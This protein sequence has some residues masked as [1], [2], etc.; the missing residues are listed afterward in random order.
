MIFSDLLGGC[1]AGGAGCE[2]ML[3]EGSENSNKKKALGEI[4]FT[5]TGS[6]SCFPARD[7]YAVQARHVACS[8]KGTGKVEMRAEFGSLPGILFLPIIIAIQ[9]ARSCFMHAGSFRKTR[10]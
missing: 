9:E 7:A 10:F 6:F 3:K 2:L 5:G 8:K 4:E 1:V